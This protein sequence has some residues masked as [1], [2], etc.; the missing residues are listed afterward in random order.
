MNFPG[1]HELIIILVII[2]ILFGAKRLP[3]LGKSLG[4]GIK[5]FRKSTK[6]LVDDDEDE[7]KKDSE[8]KSDE[9]PNVSV[10]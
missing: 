2:L 5:E 7:K 1:G 8:T 3:E 9:E 6:A 10:K 4:Q